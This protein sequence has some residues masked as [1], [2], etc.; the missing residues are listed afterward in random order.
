MASRQG[1]HSMTADSDHTALPRDRN[2]PEF[3]RRVMCLTCFRSW[4]ISFRSE[5]RRRGNLDYRTLRCRSGCT[6]ELSP[7]LKLA[8]Q[9][10]YNPPE[11]IPLE[12]L[13]RY[14][15]QKRRDWKCAPQDI[16]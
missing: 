8:V 4:R 14:E 7:E 1:W 11:E 12:I 5:I 3:P 15:K 6:A 9:L 16:D 13:A 2:H 10:L